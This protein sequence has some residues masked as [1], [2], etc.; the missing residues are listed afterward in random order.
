MKRV[1]GI[2]AFSRAFYLDGRVDV[3]VLLE[4]GRRG[5]RFAALGTGVSAGA[6]VRRT[7]VPLQI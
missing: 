3:G 4:T 6:D 2:A 1:D 7:D 5:E